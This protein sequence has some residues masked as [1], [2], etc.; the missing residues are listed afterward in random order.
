MPDNKP[1][2]KSKL[3]GL[4]K[5]N[6]YFDLPNLLSKR[7]GNDSTIQPSQSRKQIKYKLDRINQLKKKKEQ[8]NT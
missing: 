4:T 2:N 3:E 8:R 5:M 1:V 6:S 7:K